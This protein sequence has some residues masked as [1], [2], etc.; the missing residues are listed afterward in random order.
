MMREGGRLKRFVID[1][2]SKKDAADYDLDV[3]F[4][5]NSSTV[6]VTANDLYFEGEGAYWTKDNKMIKAKIKGDLS[7]SMKYDSL[8]L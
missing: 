4:P 7:V 2:K 8:A 1:V 6:V 5:T 3:A